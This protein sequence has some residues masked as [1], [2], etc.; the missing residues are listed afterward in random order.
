MQHL[1]ERIDEEK[2]ATSQT[3]LYMHH[4]SIMSDIAP[5]VAAVLR[6]KVVE[7]LLEENKRLRDQIDLQNRVEITGFGGTPLYAR[8][9]FNERIA[10]NSR[11]SCVGNPNMWEIELTTVQRCA[12]TDLWGIDVRIGGVQRSGFWNPAPDYFPYK[13]SNLSG[14]D[15]QFY[16]ND[17]PV[18]ISYHFNYGGIFL[19]TE[20]NSSRS[21]MIQSGVMNDGEDYP[22]APNTKKVKI[23]QRTFVLA[24]LTTSE[25]LP[26]PNR[27]HQLDFFPSPFLSMIP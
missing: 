23:H 13:D 25:I 27:P 5:F 14:G 18:R 7:D 15:V 2:D 11:K 26:K 1:F 12:Y 9:K 21:E 10:N 16:I 3:L 4:V 24:Y 22:G 6:D 20:I 8:G 19:Q 17:A